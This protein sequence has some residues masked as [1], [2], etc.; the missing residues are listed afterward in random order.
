M[1]A[2]CYLP[3]RWPAKYCRLCKS[4]RPCSGWERVVYLR[5]TT[6]KLSVCWLSFIQDSS[7]Y[8]EDCIRYNS[9]ICLTNSFRLPF[10]RLTLFELLLYATLSFTPFCYTKF[11]SLSS[12]ILRV[13]VLCTFT[14]RKIQL[15][16]ALV[17]LVSLGWKCCHSY[18]CDLSTL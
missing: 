9:S 15:E 8:A 1:L 7:L 5:L 11:R 18:T 6:N 10:Y 2:A 16:K 17:L 14:L 13:S 3:R 12:A 4:L